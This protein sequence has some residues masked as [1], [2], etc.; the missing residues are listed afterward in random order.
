[1]GLNPSAD[2][3]DCW[4]TEKLSS[5]QLKNEHSLKYNTKLDP[6]LS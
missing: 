6:S 2:K 5:A 4:V 1:M 3:L